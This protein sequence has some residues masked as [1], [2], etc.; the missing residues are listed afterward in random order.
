MNRHN[1]HNYGGVFPYAFSGERRLFWLS[2]DV[3]STD[4]HKDVGYE[5]GVHQ[6]GMN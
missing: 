5:E 4:V 1:L 2:T 3:M 6:C